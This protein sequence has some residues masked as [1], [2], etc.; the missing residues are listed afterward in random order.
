MTL[1]SLLWCSAS[2][3]SCATSSTQTNIAFTTY[4]NGS[5]SNPYYIPN[6]VFDNSNNEFITFQLGS[7]DANTTLNI[8]R[9]SSSGN[10]L[11]SKTYANISTGIYRDSIQLS[12][13]NSSLF[14]TGFVNSTTNYVFA[15][16]N[17]G[18]LLSL[19]KYA[20]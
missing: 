12:N 16:I 2:M 5:A 6:S 10:V 11:W 15:N 9:L 4:N 20:L 17:A 18:K 3:Q 7:G 13:D 1:L 8:A 14:V 19:I